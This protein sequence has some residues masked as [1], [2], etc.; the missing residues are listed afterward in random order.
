M[1]KSIQEKAKDFDEIPAPI[2]LFPGQDSFEDYDGPLSI[3]CE[4][5]MLSNGGE[6][7]QCE[8]CGGDGRPT[9]PFKD[10]E[11]NELLND[12]LWQEA[13]ENN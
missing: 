12:K 13:Q 8:C 11:H 6:P 9:D 3:C 5:P 10:E 4:A 1:K 2:D 7:C